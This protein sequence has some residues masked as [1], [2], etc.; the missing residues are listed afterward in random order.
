MVPL[1]LHARHVALGALCGE[2]RGREVVERT[3]GH[4]EDAALRTG[5]ALFDASAR[6]V[7]RVTGPDRVSFVQ[8]MVTQDVEG[9]PPGGVADA[10]L[11]T[12]KGA[13]VSDARVVKR[14]EDL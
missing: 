6:E 10:A 12:P 14:A 8:G 11:L 2:L 3:P 9:L 7:V 1:P 13:M 5:A 4:D